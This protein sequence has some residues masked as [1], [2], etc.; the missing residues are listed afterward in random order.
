LSP[1]TQI[2]PLPPKATTFVISDGEYPLRVKL[3]DSD[4]KD[5]YGMVRPL[6]MTIVTIAVNNFD[7]REDRD[8]YLQ[9]LGLPAENNSKF[10]TNGN[11]L[12]HT[13]IIAKIPPT[14]VLIAEDDTYQLKLHE[15]FYGNIFFS[16]VDV[17]GADIAN[18]IITPP[19]IPFMEIEYTM[20]FD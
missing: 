14:G 8:L 5:E 11:E 19:A 18:D 1:P 2:L 10:S 16:V 12:E 15:Q 7:R 9:V 20:Q 3:E 6:V 13:H 17:T 4:Y